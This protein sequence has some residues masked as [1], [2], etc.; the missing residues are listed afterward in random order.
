MTQMR[1]TPRECPRAGVQPRRDGMCCKIRRV[2]GLVPDQPA[3][4][5]MLC[6]RCDAKKVQVPAG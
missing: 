1:V 6:Q 5:E 3:A 4:E 2:G